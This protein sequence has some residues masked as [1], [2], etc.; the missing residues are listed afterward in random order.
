VK[1]EIKD[2]ILREI[3]GNRAEM[4]LSSKD[5]ILS[6]GMIDSMGVM[7]LINF[8]EN[9]SGIKIP[10]EDMVIE[11]FMTIEAMENYIEK[12]KALR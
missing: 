1:E 8:I 12:R 6:N 4:E 9:R 3:L 5:D 7:Q 10:P 2:Y 11:N